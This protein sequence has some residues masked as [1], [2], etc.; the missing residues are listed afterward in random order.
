MN[1]LLIEDE[2]ALS[3]VAAIQLRNLGNTV[4]TVCN[5]EEAARFLENPEARLDLII[6]DHRLPDGEGI[7]FIIERVRAGCTI[8]TVVVS[9]CLTVADVAV[10]EREDIPYFRKPVIYSEVV[11]RFASP[12]PRKGEVLEIRLDEKERRGGFFSGLFRRR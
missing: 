11:R 2:E 8:P 5:L 10:L 9:G 7:D 6:A 3:E 4:K 12:P 1:I